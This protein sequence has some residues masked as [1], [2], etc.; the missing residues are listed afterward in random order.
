MLTEAGDTWRLPYGP[1]SESVLVGS[2]Y[3][4][5]GAGLNLRAT[6]SRLLY[7]RHGIV[8]FTGR[9]A[10]VDQIIGW[11]VDTTARRPGLAVH[12]ITGGG[13]ATR[14]G[15]PPKCA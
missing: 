8:P 6:L 1:G 13:G 7:L 12:T 10:L 11:C 3:E 15:S 4:P 14:P 5:L 9:R 2:P